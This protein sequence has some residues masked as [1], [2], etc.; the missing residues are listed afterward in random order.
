MSPRDLARAHAAGRMVVGAGLVAA[1]ELIGVPWVGRDAR[2]GALH[3]YS[4]A[5]GARDAGLGAGLWAANAQGH[6][7]RPW[8]L[9]GLA[10]DAADLVA[11][12]R[13]RGALPALGVATTVAIAGGSIAIG[14]WL[15]GRL[16]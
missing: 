13:N 15:Q 2:R 6:G 1:P 7:A 9:A 11:T 3:V 5:L 4:A 14:A 10:A 12:W 8:I 16:D